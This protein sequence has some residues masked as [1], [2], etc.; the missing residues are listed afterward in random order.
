MLFFVK[1]AAIAPL[2]YQTLRILHMTKSTSTQ[3]YKEEIKYAQVLMMISFL[4]VIIMGPMGS[5]LMMGLG[6]RLLTKHR[7]RNLPVTSR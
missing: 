1:Q 7:Q 2:A 3:R 6:P 5:M 4:T